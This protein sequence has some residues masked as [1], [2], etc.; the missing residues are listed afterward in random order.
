MNRICV[1]QIEAILDTISM[2]IAHV[3]KA[4][5]QLIEGLFMPE[6]KNCKSN[7]G[8]MLSRT[9]RNIL[10]VRELTKLSTLHEHITFS[11]GLLIHKK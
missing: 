3:E 9:L 4:L 10:H 5:Q 11:L 6:A 8:E 2:L 1:S 7:M